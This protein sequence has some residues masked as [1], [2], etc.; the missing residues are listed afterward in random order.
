PEFL[1][2]QQD[3]S[4]ILI[5]IMGDLFPA[6]ISRRFHIAITRRRRCRDN[7]DCRS[8]AVLDPGA[9]LHIQKI[10][11]MNEV[12]DLEQ[13][14]TG[15]WRQVDDDEATRHCEY[16]CPCCAVHPGHDSVHCDECRRNKTPFVEEERYQFEGDSKYAIIVFSILHP[17]QRKDWALTPNCCMDR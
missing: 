6:D 12:I 14:L 8:P 1:N 16:C 5:M 4:E 10:S 9:P 13:I 2:T 11:T 3:A 15:E 7:L 17:T